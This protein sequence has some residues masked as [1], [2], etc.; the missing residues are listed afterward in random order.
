MYVLLVLVL[1]LVLVLG[2]ILT[3]MVVRK[4]QQTQKV[5][6]ASRFIIMA[7]RAADQLVMRMSAYEHGFRGARCLPQVKVALPG[8]NFTPILIRAIYHGNSPVRRASASFAG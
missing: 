1:V 4:L 2:S 3:T 8:N 5:G 6:S 7:D